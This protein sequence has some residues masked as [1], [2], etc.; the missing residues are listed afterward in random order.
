MTCPKRK[1]IPC[2]IVMTVSNL[3]REAVLKVI[4]AGIRLDGRALEDH[5]E[6]KFEFSN[7]NRGNLFLSLGRTR[8]IFIL[9]IFFDFFF[10]VQAIVSATLDRPFPD[11]P[12]EG[13][14]SFFVEYSGTALNLNGFSPVGTRLDEEQFGS[15][16]QRTL[17]KAFKS[18]RAVDM[19]SLCVVTGQRVWNVR[20][21][22]H[23]LEDEGNVLDAVMLA[24][25]AALSDFRRP[26]VMV[27]A[28]Q[29]VTIFSSFER[30]PVP[31]SLHHFPLSVSFGIF[32][33]SN[34]SP[35]GLVDPTSIEALAQESSISFVMNRQ[36]E[37]VHMI[38]PGGNVFNS[39]FLLNDLLSTAKSS[40]IKLSDAVSLAVASRP[41]VSI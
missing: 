5:R 33:D 9:F 21:D 12:F 29:E 34:N 40:S 27:S 23:V 37:I 1:Q 15:S 17:E 22:I 8:Y 35:V 18:S 41:S 30:H 14:L 36:G 25:L 28:E 39:D 11:R 2:K 32:Q 19:E 13:Q 24:T 31:L 4:S 20:V 3:E 7:S 26:D 6:I 10:S 16:I 38:K